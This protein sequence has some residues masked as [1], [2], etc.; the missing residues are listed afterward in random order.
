[1]TDFLIRSDPDPKRREAYDADAASYLDGLPHSVR[2]EWTIGGLRFVLSCNRETP[3]FAHRE[4]NELTVATGTGSQS[5]LLSRVSRRRGSR[6]HRDSRAETMYNCWSADVPFGFMAHLQGEHRAFVAAD[7]LGLYPVYYFRS[8]DIQVIASTPSLIVCHPK[9]RGSVDRVALTGI[10]LFSFPSGQRTLWKQVKRLSPGHA[11]KCFPD[12]SPREQEVWTP[13]DNI[14]SGTVDDFASRFN[15]E[16][17]TWRNSIE[18]APNFQ[19]S[20]GLDSRVVAGYLADSPSR[21][22]EAWTYGQSRDLEAQVAQKVASQCRFDHQVVPVDTD[23]Y[24]DWAYAEIESN[25]LTSAAPDFAPWALG[26]HAANDDR[27]VVSGHLGDIIMGGN[28]IGRAL[29][30]DIS[31]EE[32]FATICARLNEGY[33][34]AEGAIHRVLRGGDTDELIQKCRA[35]LY[36]SYTKYGSNPFKRRWYFDLLHRDRLIIGRLILQIARFSWPELPYCTPDMVR[37]ASTIPGAA[38]KNRKVQK[39]VLKTQFPRLAR[40]PLTRGEFDTWPLSY[41]S[42]LSRWKWRIWEGLAWRWRKGLQSVLGIDRR[43]NHRLWDINRNPGWRA[44]RQEARSH[45]SAAESL[46][47][48]EIL[49]IL[50]PPPEDSIEVSD[51]LSGTGRKTLMEFILWARRFL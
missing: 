27:R 29:G 15:T 38:L 13:S 50:L 47:D 35:E 30:T 48:E 33:G 18:G 42:R 45:V 26:D 4:G 6:T 41:A 25:H 51:A 3:T 17:E 19:L 36:A 2:R 31:T 8:S 16:L 37:A 12:T 28:H 9:V 22:R 7:R 43:V 34:L 44:I 23:R 21:I 24:L 39:Y 10:L 1:M 14:V 40:V 46:L 32:A 49:R 5:A 20:G 11:L